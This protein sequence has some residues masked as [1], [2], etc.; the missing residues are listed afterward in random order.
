MLDPSIPSRSSL[1]QG[2]MPN[3]S[4]FGQGMC[5]NM[6]TVARGRRSRMNLGTSAKW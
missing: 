3:R 2:Q 6:M 4:E 1:R 5:Q